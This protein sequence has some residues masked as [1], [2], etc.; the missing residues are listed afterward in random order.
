MQTAALQKYGKR[1]FLTLEFSMFLSQMEFGHDS[2][3]YG[4]VLSQG[5]LFRIHMTP[6][7]GPKLGE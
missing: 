3:E 1:N 6:A 7:H 5:E 2:K 4:H